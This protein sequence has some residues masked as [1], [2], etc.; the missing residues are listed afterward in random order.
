MLDRLLDSLHES[1]PTAMLKFSSFLIISFGLSCF[2]SILGYRELAERLVEVI[3]F[4]VY[5]LVLVTIL[6]YSLIWILCLIS[7]RR[8]DRDVKKKGDGDVTE[9]DR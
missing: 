7:L 1:A 8:L 2:I 3:I 4:L 5:L 6:I 9:E